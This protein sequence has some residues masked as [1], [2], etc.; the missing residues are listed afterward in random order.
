VNDEARGMWEAAAVAISKY[1]PSIRPRILR[2]TTKKNTI[3][4]TY[5]LP[6]SLETIGM[7]QLP[8]TPGLTTSFHKALN[9]L[10][11]KVYLNSI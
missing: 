2:K 1:Y 6:E 11:G 4:V 7:E 9:P 3:A 8:T 5:P 10:N